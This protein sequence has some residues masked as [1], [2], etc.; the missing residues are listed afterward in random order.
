VL[1]DQPT[2]RVKKM[3]AS[4]GMPVDQFPAM[5]HLVSKDSPDYQKEMDNNINPPENFKILKDYLNE[6]FSVEEQTKLKNSKYFYEIVFE[7]PGGLVMPILMDI[8]F[9]DGSK[10]SFNYPALI[11][12]YNDKEVKKVFPSEKEIKEI[13][14]DP[15]EITADVNTSNNFWPRKPV[16]NKFEEFKKKNE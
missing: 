2:D 16:V 10:E 6:N 5:I 7:K 14:I 11:W 13:I 3:A 15:K 12:R 1:T 9:T 8:I 4:Y